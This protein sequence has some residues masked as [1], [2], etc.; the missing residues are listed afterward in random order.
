MEASQSSSNSA[1]LLRDL[2]AGFLVFL[3]ALPLCLGISLASGFPPIAG[4]MTAIIGGLVATWAGSADLTIKGPAAGLIVIA[5]GSFGE[6]GY[7]KTLA[8]GVVAASLQILFALLRAGRFGEIFPPAVVHGMLAAIGVII[9]SKQLHTMVGVK[10]E[11]HE[12]LGLL[13][14]IPKSLA[15]M[16]PEI[17][18][19]GGLS[20]LLLL[21]LPRVSWPALRRVPAPLIVLAVAV[22]L[23]TWFDLAHT[24][25]YTFLDEVHEVVL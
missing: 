15:N 20:L 17:A 22:P 5:L 23:A 4:I 12:P 2:R 24:H 11:A 1:T 3:I 7:E 8:V 13:A 16:N 14:E 9:M 19:I 10:P 25:P 18:L 21:A 6:L